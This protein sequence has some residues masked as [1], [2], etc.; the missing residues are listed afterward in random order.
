MGERYLRYVNWMPDVAKRAAAQAAGWLPADRHSKW[1]NY[2]RWRAVSWK[3]SQLSFTERYRAY[4]GSFSPSEAQQLQRAGSHVRYDALGAAF[5]AVGGEDAL[6]R[7]FAADALTQLPDDLLLLTDKM[8]MATSL[9]CR[10]PH[11]R[12]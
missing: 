6:A 5:D 11:A 2:A 10:V 7:M 1:L 8:T 4:V 12:P 9:E 3:S